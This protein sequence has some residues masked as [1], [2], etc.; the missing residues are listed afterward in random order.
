MSVAKSTHVYYT[1]LRKKS[2]RLFFGQISNYGRIFYETK[3]IWKPALVNA[4]V[5]LVCAII[6][7]SVSASSAVWMVIGISLIVQAVL[8]LVTTFFPGKKKDDGVVVEPNE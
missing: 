6:I 1:C 2:Q 5:T 8:D 3:I 4:A 7:I